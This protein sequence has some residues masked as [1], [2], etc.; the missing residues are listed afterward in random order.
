VAY[1]AAVD[2]K[3]GSLVAVAVVAVFS[4]C[5][6]LPSTALA[7]NGDMFAQMKGDQTPSSGDPQDPDGRGVGLIDIRVN[8]GQ[9]CGNAHF[10]RIGRN[11]L[12]LFISTT[13]VLDRLI[14]LD[15]IFGGARCVNGIDANLLQDIKEAPAQYRLAVANSAH[16]DAAIAGALRRSS[17][18]SGFSSGLGPT[19]LFAR[20]NGG[21]EV[22]GPGDPDGR[23]ASL[24][25]VTPAT[26]GICADVRWQSIAAR[27]GMH[28]HRG[29]ITASGPIVVGFFNP[30]P[31]TRCTTPTPA[32]AQEIADFPERFYLNVHTA[33]S[34]SAGAIRGQLQPGLEAPALRGSWFP[35]T[36]KLASAPTA[37]PHDPLICTLRTT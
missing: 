21:S 32:L 29:G 20:M 15:P 4:V 34:F 18:D 5:C 10:R 12:D 8:E 13:D 3:P 31:E 24:I 9:V 19:P 36:S 17:V 11:G 37:V 23:G 22:P 35:S 7:A 14:D 25:S 6:C 27:T 2:V 26:G 16:P 1:D 33:P 28:I 30:G